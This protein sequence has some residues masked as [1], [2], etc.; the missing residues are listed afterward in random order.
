[1][2]ALILANGDPPEPEFIL[3]LAAESDLV[4]AT[5]GAA[6]RAAGLGLTPHLITGDFDSAR[7]E[8]VRLEF[9]HAEMLTTPDQNYTDLE[10]AIRLVLE[11]GAKQITVVGATG[12]RLDQT[13]AN[14]L[15]ALRY[16]LPGGIVIRDEMGALWGLD[17]ADSPVEYSWRTAPG[18]VVSLISPD[19]RARIRLTG[20]EWPLE[21]E[22]LPLGTRGVSNV[23]LGVTV[24]AHVTGGS[25]IVCHQAPS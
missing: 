6:H 22:I 10:K 3:R 2:R 8:I 11:R 24:T 13:V 7:P 5:D 20:V 1:M 18:D 12:G 21:D 4:V 25:V 19:G 15:L 14:F 23:A 9:P 17:G 16:P